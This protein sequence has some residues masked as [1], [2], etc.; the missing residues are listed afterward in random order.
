[1]LMILEEKHCQNWDVLHFSMPGRL[2]QADH[3][4][5]HTFARIVELVL[6]NMLEQEMFVSLVLW[7]AQAVYHSPPL[8]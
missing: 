8:D 3:N 6:E 4:L 2:G 1:M 5:L 7:M